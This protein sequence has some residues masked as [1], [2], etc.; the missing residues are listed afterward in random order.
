MGKKKTAIVSE[1][2]EMYLDRQDLALAL[3]RLED[4]EEEY[5]ELDDFFAEL[6][7]GVQDRH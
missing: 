5:L 6:N 4:P 7:D 1:A 3:K 2:L